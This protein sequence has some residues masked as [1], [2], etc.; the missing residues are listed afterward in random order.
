M[1]LS[2]LTLAKGKTTTQAAL[3]I[4]LLTISAFAFPGNTVPHAR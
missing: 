1:S 4:I 3:P 2:A